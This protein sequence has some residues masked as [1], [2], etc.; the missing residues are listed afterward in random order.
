MNAGAADPQ[1]QGWFCVT[2][3]PSVVALRVTL[4]DGGFLVVS[5]N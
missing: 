1:G 2:L 4:E 3:T 5:L